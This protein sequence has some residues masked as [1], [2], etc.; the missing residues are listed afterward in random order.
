[1]TPFAAK[2]FDFA[3]EVAK[4]QRDAV[5]L[6]SAEDYQKWWGSNDDSDSG[7]R[8]DDGHTGTDGPDQ[9]DGGERGD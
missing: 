2:L 5:C 4:R 3:V 8:S 9:A 7:T 1:M 6:V